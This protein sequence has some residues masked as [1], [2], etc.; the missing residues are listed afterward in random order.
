MVE[1]LFVTTSNSLTLDGRKLATQ[2]DRHRCL[3]R[4]L[5][6][7]EL[8]PTP[9]SE[10]GPAPNRTAI[11]ANLVFLR[12]LAPGHHVL[13]AEVRFDSGEEFSAT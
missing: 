9:S 11:R 4:E 1:E 12:P 3:H 7:G 13:E 6:A 10:W 2:V 5:G 8:L